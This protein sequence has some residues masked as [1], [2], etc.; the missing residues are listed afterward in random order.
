M[1]WLVQIGVIAGCHGD[2][3][4]ELGHKCSLK[5]SKKQAA[6]SRI[7][8]FCL[9]QLRMLHCLLRYFPPDKLTLISVLTGTKARANSL[10][11][12]GNVPGTLAGHKHK[13][14]RLPG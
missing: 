3:V 6:Y 13:T 12:G 10:R 5:F 2:C 11:G 14:Q 7:F 8:N 1:G 4:M 9:G